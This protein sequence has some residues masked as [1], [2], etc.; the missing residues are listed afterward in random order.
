LFGVVLDLLLFGILT[1]QVYTYYLAFPTDRMAT[2]LAVMS[3]YA[4]GLAQTT[5]AMI[6]LYQTTW[7][8]VPGLDSFFS[9]WDPFLQPWF[10]VYVSGAVAALIVQCFYAYRIFIVSRKIWISVLIVLLSTTQVVGSTLAAVSILGDA[11]KSLS[12]VIGSWVRTILSLHN[13]YNANVTDGS[14]PLTEHPGIVVTCYALLVNFN[15]FEPV[16]LIPGLAI[17]KTYSNSMLALLNNRLEIVSGRNSSG[18]EATWNTM[19][20]PPEFD[21]SENDRQPI[22]KAPAESCRTG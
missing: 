8:S 7:C 19:E 20:I 17:G 18:S 3:V 6:D 10:S 5:V 12:L 13:N 22:T 4:L 16:Y 11:A 14:I 1:V 2:K 21:Q 9:H 15:L